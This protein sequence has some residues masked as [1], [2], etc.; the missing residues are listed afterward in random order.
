[1]EFPAIPRSDSP[2]FKPSAAGKCVVAFAKDGI[3]HRI[4]I[5]AAW[6][7]S[8]N[9][10][11]WQF[12]LGYFCSRRY[13]RS[14]PDVFFCGTANLYGYKQGKHTNIGKTD[15]SPVGFSFVQRSP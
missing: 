5:A 2:F 11:R 10:V 6:F 1:M 12:S 7:S 3:R 4:A 13:R 14:Y 9:R 15:C 8:W